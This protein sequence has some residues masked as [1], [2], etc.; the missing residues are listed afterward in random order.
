MRA[1]ALALGAADLLRQIA[2]RR[3]SLES[4]AKWR[5][6]TP[7]RFVAKPPRSESTYRKNGRLVIT[8]PDTLRR[9]KS[10]AIAELRAEAERR[11]YKYDHQLRR[12]V[13]RG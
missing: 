12:P 3:G 13:A 7:G 10:E 11:G 4:A 2:R 8:D 5:T 1:E 6:S 9:A